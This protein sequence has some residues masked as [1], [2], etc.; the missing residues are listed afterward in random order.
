V[1]ITGGWGVGFTDGDGDDVF[2]GR[3]GAQW[4]WGRSADAYAIK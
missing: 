3:L 2:G 1:A 4:T